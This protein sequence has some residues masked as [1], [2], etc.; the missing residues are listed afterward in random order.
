M[1]NALHYFLITR[2]K[3]EVGVTA[4]NYQLWASLFPTGVLRVQDVR[5]KA[6]NMGKRR[7][8]E[9]LGDFAREWQNDPAKEHF[10][11]RAGL[12]KTRAKKGTNIPR[13]DIRIF[14]APSGNDPAK[15]SL[16]EAV[17]ESVRRFSV[18]FDGVS[19]PQIIGQTLEAHANDPWILGTADEESDFRGLG[20]LFSD[21]F[22]ESFD[23]MVK[24]EFGWQD[25]QLHGR[26]W[27][28]YRALRQRFLSGS[29][30]Y[31]QEFDILVALFSLCVLACLVGPGSFIKELGFDSPDSIGT[32]KPLRAPSLP[33]GPHPS[34]G[35]PRSQSFQLQPI[36]FN[37]REGRSYFTSDERPLV[38]GRKD[39][40]RFGRDTE[41]LSEVSCRGIS[42]MDPDISRQHAE[43][44]NGPKGWEIVD[45]GVDSDG[46]TNG[47][48]VFRA[49][50]GPIFRKQG[51]TERERTIK[52]ESGDIIYIAPPGGSSYDVESRRGCVDPEI[53]RRGRAFRFE[54][55]V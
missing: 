17:Q 42:I 53:G 6:T 15:A 46:S 2:F 14:V 4:D 48:L 54:R 13:E 20:F 11:R 33:G 55:R 40:V 25:E 12:L 24:V 7:Y 44:R 45:G 29:N 49:F 28:E 50:G 38:F 39:I 51:F 30:N 9:L 8:D 43:L 47:I 22:I 35:D 31:R 36:I 21:E 3:E 34:G 10:V 41:W 27:Q 5:A 19:H 16:V 26:F 37:G 23:A 32:V 18:T 52:I 1:P